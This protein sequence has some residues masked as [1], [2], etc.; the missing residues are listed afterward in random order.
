MAVYNW[1]FSRIY[2]GLLEGHYRASLIEHPNVRP[3]L[4]IIELY[5]GHYRS[6]MAII[7]ETKRAV[8]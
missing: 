6:I 4:A 3:L 2:N 7:V 5:N 1:G 8:N